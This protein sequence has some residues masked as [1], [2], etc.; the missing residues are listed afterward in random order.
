MAGRR[1]D[2]GEPEFHARG[3]DR[4]RRAGRRRRHEEQIDLAAPPTRQDFDWRE[5]T[6]DYEALAAYHDAEAQAGH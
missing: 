5:E 1:R 4:D 2:R 3:D 6:Q